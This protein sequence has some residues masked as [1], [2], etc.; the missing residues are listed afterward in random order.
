MDIPKKEIAVV[1][2][3]NALHLNFFF[4]FSAISLGSMVSV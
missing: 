4:V 2:E 3:A 1:T